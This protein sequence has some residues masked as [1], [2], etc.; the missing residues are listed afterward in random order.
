MVLRGFAAAVCCSI[1]IAGDNPS[2][3][4]TSGF[5]SRSKNCCA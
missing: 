5:S 3:L 1:A 2:M 4:S